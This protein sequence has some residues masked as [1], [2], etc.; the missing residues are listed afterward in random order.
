MGSRDSYTLDSDIRDLLPRFAPSMEATARVASIR[1]RLE[2]ADMQTVV[3]GA[4]KSGL[5]AAALLRS[6]GARVVVAEDRVTPE[7]AAHVAALGADLAAIE[8]ATFETAELVVLSPGVPRNKPG[9]QPAIDRQIVVGEIELAS[10]FIQVP[11]IGIT[12]T[13]GKSTTTA[14]VAHILKEA[15]R[16]VFA[17]G[18]LGEPLSRLAMRPDD[19][20]IAVVEL[21]SY[22]L[23]SIVDARFEVACWLNL[24][25]DHLE[26]YRDI[27]QYAAAKERLLARRAANGVAVLNAK[28]PYC[29]DR[30]IRLGGPIRWFAGETKS[31]LAQTMGTLL[32]ESGDALR[33][34]EDKDEIEHYTLSGAG[35]IGAHNKANACAAIECVRHF[36]ID[37]AL[38]N[39]GL[40]T[41]RGLPHRIE[42]VGTIDGVRYYN[43]SKATNVDSAIIAILA[44]S[45]PKILIAGGKDKGA[46]WA[47]LVE[48]AVA[49]DVKAVLTVGEA[50]PIVEAAFSGRV[51]RVVHCGDIHRA[52]EEARRLAVAGD[53]VLLSPGCASFDQFK[54]FEH[55]GDVFRAIVQ[56]AAGRGTA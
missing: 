28:D 8:P 9:L 43:D 32:S 7:N 3:V 50:A 6:K 24:T 18:N 23:E 13:N 44:V 39:R 47:P 51:P 25:P 41:F 46:P 34:S 26:R 17:G 48:A 49:Q 22:Q 54:N 11:M 36:E 52:F 16:R 15:G 35:L 30:G 55:R 33:A 29:S 31:K 21:S 2:R 53:A 27:D 42:A 38:V 10:W 45:G 1:V 14:L 12:G 56:A 19:F 20:D 5:A 37:P 40:S 4:G